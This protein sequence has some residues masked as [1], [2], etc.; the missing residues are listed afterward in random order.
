MKSKS[1]TYNSKSQWVLAI[2]LVLISLVFITPVIY[3]IVTSFKLE[4]DIIGSSPTF[5]PRNP[6]FENYRY[7][8]ERRGVYL[9]Y[10][11]NSTVITIAGVLITT[12]LSTMCGYAFARLPFKGRNVIMGFILF[13]VTFPLAVLLIPIYIMEYEVGLLNTNLGLILPNVTTV[14]PFSIFVMR[15]IFRSIPKELEESAEIDGASVF[16]TWWKIMMPIGL[17]GISIVIIFC[18]YNIWGEYILARTLATQTPAMPLT[19]GLTLLRGEGWSYGILGAVIFLALLPPV[20]IFM[21]F[22]KQLI[23]GITKGA[24]KG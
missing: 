11:Y 22:Q 17:N 19:V 2:L 9:L 15:G 13:I 7:I 4:K 18:F 21:I 5:F 16:A 1:L 8:F 12:V 24:I 14:L 3:A 10:Y 23:E 6:S 20:I